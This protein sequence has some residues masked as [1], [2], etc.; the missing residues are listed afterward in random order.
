M[1]RGLRGVKLVISDAHEGLKAAVAKVLKATWQRYREHFMRNL[2]ATVA[3]R[4]RSVVAALI[5]TIFAQEPP[6]RH[7]RSA[8]HGG[9]TAPTLSES[10]ATDGPGRARCTR[11]HGFP[12]GS[13]HQSA[14]DQSAGA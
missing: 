6:K 4:Q 12:Q 1:R 7:G 13:P 11:P 5:R 2:L 9:S 3:K 8:H 10:G 14:L